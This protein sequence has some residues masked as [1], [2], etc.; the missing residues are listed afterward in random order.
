MEMFVENY[1]RVQATLQELVQVQGSLSGTSKTAIKGYEK[2]LQKFE[3]LLGTNASVALFG[4]CKQLVRML[5][6]PVY[7][8]AG[9]K[10]AAEAL[11]DRLAK[12]RS[13]ASFDVPWQRTNSSKRVGSKGTSC[14]QSFAAAQN[15]SIHRQA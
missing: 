7:H 10:A 4:P 14:V 8:A 12:L 5:E 6:R 11:C 9:A 3:T 15:A 13:D 2:V 1:E